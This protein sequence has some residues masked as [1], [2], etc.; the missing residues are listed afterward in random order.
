MVAYQ[1]PH[2]NEVCGL[3]YESDC[4]GCRGTADAAWRIREREAEA[5]RL[6]ALILDHPEQLR[7]A[8]LAILTEPIAD[9]A[10]AVAR[11][12]RP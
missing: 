1:G 11:E 2:D 5:A 4:P 10:L 12:V 3:G 8:L 7:D 9:I 6:A